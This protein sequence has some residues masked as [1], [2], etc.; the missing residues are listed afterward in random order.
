MLEFLTQTFYNVPMTITI[1]LFRIQ[2]FTIDP[3]EQKHLQMSPHRSIL[4][5]NRPMY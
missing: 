4:I 2:T 3:E 1:K 5:T